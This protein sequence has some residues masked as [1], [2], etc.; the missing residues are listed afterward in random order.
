MPTYRHI[1]E[2]LLRELGR[3]SEAE[4]EWRHG[5]RPLANPADPRHTRGFAVLQAIH[6]TFF[7]YCAVVDWE[8][9][10]L[11]LF[12]Y[13]SK[14]GGGKCSRDIPLPS[15]WARRVRTVEW[16]IQSNRFGCLLADCPF[17][18]D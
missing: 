9:E 6:R 7:E 4:L 3:D 2:P 14:S 15:E 16:P 18:R 13:D 10:R 11:H 1:I 5:D 17:R 12:Q 8:N